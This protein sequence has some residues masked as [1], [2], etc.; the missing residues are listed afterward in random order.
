MRSQYWITA[1]GQTVKKIIGACITCKR[2]EGISYRSPP[3]VPLPD[4]RV[5][6]ERPLKY[7]GID[8]C[9][10]AYMRTASH[11]EKNYI[12]LMTCAATRMIHLE[13]VRDLS[14]TLYVQCLK[15]FVGGENCQNQYYQIMVKPSKQTSLKFPTQ[16]MGLFGDST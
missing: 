16:K 11:T 1:G 15:R 14:A 7:T 4:F 6:Q 8:C 10:P 2:L 13:L 9:G 5:H 3:T 12:V